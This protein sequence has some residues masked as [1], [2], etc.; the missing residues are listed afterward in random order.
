M[1][2][3][4]MEDQTKAKEGKE[5]KQNEV[6]QYSFPSSY[7][8][9]SRALLPPKPRVLEDM[10]GIERLT[11]VVSTNLKGLVPPHNETNLSSRLRG[12]DL[13]LS[14]SSLLPLGSRLVESEELGSPV[15]PPHEI[16]EQVSWKERTRG[17]RGKRG[18]REEERREGRVW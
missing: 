2:L 17:E 12:K 4:T 1:S 5:T 6:S 16:K 15:P 18:R 13:D 3:L 11:D 7:L 9:S 10:K 8:S 14:G